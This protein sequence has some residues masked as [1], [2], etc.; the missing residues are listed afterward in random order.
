M[1][2]G[3]LF[4]FDRNDQKSSNNP[5]V[6]SS[7]VGTTSTDF[8]SKLAETISTYPRF[9]Y[10]GIPSHEIV[11]VAMRAAEEIKNAALHHLQPALLPKINRFENNLHEMV[12]RTRDSA[13]VDDLYVN[14]TAGV[15]IEATRNTGGTYK[16][17]INYAPIRVDANDPLIQEAI[18]PRSP[19][20]DLRRRKNI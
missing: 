14:L 4:Q 5:E 2:T 12:A 7:I 11:D 6:E 18:R 3:R 15:Q 20:E 10:N 9:E 16:L 19:V 13:F 17:T 8:I 1:T